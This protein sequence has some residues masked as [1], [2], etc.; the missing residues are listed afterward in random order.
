MCFSPCT[1]ISNE[2][3]YFLKYSKN[4]L[5]DSVE[6]IEHRIIKTVFRDYGISGVDFNSS[7]DVPAGTGL[8]SSSAF[9]VGLAS[10]CNA[11][12][13]RYMSKEDIAAYA[14]DVE[15]MRLEEPIGKQ[16]QYACAVSGL[17]FIS[18]RTDDTVT[19]E[20]ILMKR[21]EIKGIAGKPPSILSREHQVGECDP[22]RAA[23]EPEGGR[24]Q[25]REPSQNDPAFN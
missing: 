10:L 22:E 12:T 19:V 2:D 14:C 24:G 25:N 17:N 1:H 4:E 6:S 20:K 13:G 16:D 11:F 3:R 5:V 9:T 8:G 18:F 23:K 7:A 21:G 15:I